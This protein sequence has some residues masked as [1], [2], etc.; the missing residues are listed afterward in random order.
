[1]TSKTG[2][3]SVGLTLAKIVKIIAI[4]N[5]KTTPIKLKKA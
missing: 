4:I 5:G 3:D 1:M 2:L